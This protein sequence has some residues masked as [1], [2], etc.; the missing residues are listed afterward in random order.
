MCESRG[1]SLRETPARGTSSGNGLRQMLSIDDLPIVSDQMADQP[2]ECDGRLGK[3]ECRRGLRG[4]VH[5][6]QQVFACWV[7]PCGDAGL[8]TRGPRKGGC[9][10]SA[11]TTILIVVT[12]SPGGP[13]T[14]TGPRM[15]SS[16]LAPLAFVSG[17]T[18]D[19]LP[20][21]AGAPLP[22][23][24]CF[25]LFPVFP[26][27]PLEAPLFSTFWAPSTPTSAASY[28]EAPHSESVAWASFVGRP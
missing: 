3:L 22:L 4:Q 25:P 5:K 19:S 7:R 27:L 26:P 21:L 16:D 1:C 24:A 13:S 8:S 20:A 6:G 15:A 23:A 18:F 28:S 11:M 17:A 14:P 12:F 2:V 9:R 10:T